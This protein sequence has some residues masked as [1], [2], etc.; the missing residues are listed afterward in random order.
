MTNKFTTPCFIRKNTPELRRKLEELE[1]KNHNNGDIYGNT[2][3]T[4]TDNPY[5][6]F[7]HFDMDD[8]FQKVIA[9]QKNM[10]DC[11]TNEALFLAIAS[12]RED[13]DYKQWFCDDNGLWEKCDSDLPSRYMQI[14]GHKATVEELINH[15][16]D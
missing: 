16:K 7:M 2:I 11:G 1:Y 10:I 12:L 5:P 13:S 3:C 9:R 14:N 4:L 15:F 6:E 8:D